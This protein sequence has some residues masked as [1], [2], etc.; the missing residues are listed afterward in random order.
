MAK[1][2]ASKAPLAIS[3]SKAALNHAR[4]HTVA[5]GLEWIA[6]MQGSLWS[7][8]DVMAAIQ[9]RM[10]RTEAEFAPL[11]PLRPFDPKV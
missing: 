1:R 7:P 8:A 4:D 11:A 10:A 2:I 9:S 5:E 6:V 3:G